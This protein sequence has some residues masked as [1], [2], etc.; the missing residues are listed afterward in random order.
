MSSARDLYLWN[1]QKREFIIYGFDPDP[2]NQEPPHVMDHEGL[3]Y[4]GS[5]C[6]SG[7]FINPPTEEALLRMASGIWQTHAHILG[8]QYD[9]SKPVVHSAKT[10]DQC[11]AFA[12][13]LEEHCYQAPSVLTLREDV[14]GSHDWSYRRFLHQHLEAQINRLPQKPRRILEVG[15]GEGTNL[16]FLKKRFP[17]IEVY[18]IDH[19]NACEIGRRAAR[20][21][22]L[23]VKIIDGDAT[24]P[25]LFPENSFDLIFVHGTFHILKPEQI[26]A[27]FKNMTRWALR[28]IFLYEPFPELWAMATARTWASLIY[29][30]SK[31]YTG[32]VFKDL[33]S[34][35]LPFDKPYRITEAGRLKNSFNPLNENCVAMLMLG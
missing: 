4:Y 5:Y 23:D 28:W 15:C 22:E 11:S 8:N 2:P 9:H 35:N 24:N 20:H 17:D 14:V 33:M 1:D 29:F 32:S 19:S 25:E 26:A 18:G 21:F 10:L 31:G 6:F 16:L 3:R 12:A 7:C 27:V 13:T 30:H 34:Q